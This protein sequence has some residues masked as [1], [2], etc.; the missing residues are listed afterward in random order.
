MFKLGNRRVQRIKTSYFVN[1][2]QKWVHHWELYKNCEV[3]VFM[4]DEYRLVVL[5]VLL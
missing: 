3:E 1:L 2:P 4:D 5:P